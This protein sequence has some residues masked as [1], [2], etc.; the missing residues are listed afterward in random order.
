MLHNRARPAPAPSIATAAAL[1]FGLVAATASPALA[2][3]PEAQGFGPDNVI[4]LIGDGMGYDQIDAAS[5]YRDGTSYNQFGV[6]PDTGEVEREP[7]EASAVYED[8][9]VQLSAATYP[10]GGSYDPAT[11][12]SDF[13]YVNNGYTDSAASGTALATGVH[14]DNGLVG[15]DPDLLPVRNLTERAQETGRASGVVSDVPFSHATPAAFVAHNED[16]SAY[17][18]IAREMLTEHEL[19]VVMGAGH[20]HRDEDGR[21]VDEA[22]YDYVDEDTYE[23]ASAGETGFT[24]VEE[25]DDFADLAETSTPPERVFGLAQVAATLQ[26]DRS[27]PDLD[28]DGEPI[29]GSEPYDAAFNEDVPS[30]AEM[31]SGALNVLDHSSDEGLFLM[32]E[33]GAIDWAGHDNNINRLIEEQNEFDRAVEA[34]V[35]WVE[36]E[37]SWQETLVVVTA[38]HETG[39]LAGPGAGEDGGWTPLT[40]EAGE[41]PEHSWHSGDHTNMLVPVYAQGPGASRMQ[42]HAHYE[43][44]VQGAYLEHT[45]IANTV[46]DFWG[47]G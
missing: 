16:R 12:W 26:Y 7:S 17:D 28:E 10:E 15:L 36:A 8:F 13:D 39:Y 9:D 38:D 18:Q 19:D 29:E 20:P 45:D 23:S 21:P 34:V 11:A 32:V 22:Q 27:G 47:R 35:D 33:G 24:F 30:L 40:G 44:P 42:H 6:D 46:F 25:A 43:D 41:L 37:S 3:D 4:V 1:A 31:A 2:D 14:T 5:L